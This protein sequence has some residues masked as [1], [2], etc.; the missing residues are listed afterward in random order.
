MEKY[1]SLFLFFNKNSSF[2][3]PC[4]EEYPCETIIDRSTDRGSSRF[5]HDQIFKKGK[6]SLLVAFPR[7]S[8]NL[9]A[10]LRGWSNVVENIGGKIY[11]IIRISLRRTIGNR[12][13]YRCYS[14]NRSTNGKWLKW[15]NPFFNYE[16]NLDGAKKRE[17]T[18]ID[19]KYSENLNR[20]ASSIFSD[21]RFFQ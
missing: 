17:L 5:I 2:I 19:R 14:L 3:F 8:K 11:W 10:F 16:R 13:V 15:K 7:L 9:F 6:F 20:R 4:K 1:S 12:R 18:W 21:K